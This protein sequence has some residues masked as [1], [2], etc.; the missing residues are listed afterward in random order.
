LN[1][2][3]ALI[4]PRPALSQ[5]TK[6]EKEQPLNSRAWGF[7]DSDQA[8]VQLASCAVTMKTG[9]KSDQNLYDRLISVNSN[10][11]ILTET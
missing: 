5:I 3:P 2:L 7:I 1:D 9:R 10:L 4:E 8:K 11:A 6:D